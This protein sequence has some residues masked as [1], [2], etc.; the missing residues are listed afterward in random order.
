MPPHS[1]TALRPHLSPLR[2]PRNALHAPAAPHALG[3]AQAFIE[4]GTG[5]GDLYGFEC[6][7]NGSL[8]PL[9]PP[10]L[11]LF[12]EGLAFIGPPSSAFISFH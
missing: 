3:R 8:C 12:V 10:L 4:A 2:P 11:Y 1:P 7:M 6:S 5:A 9:G